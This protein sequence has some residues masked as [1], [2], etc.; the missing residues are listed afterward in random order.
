MQEQ[1]CENCKKKRIVKNIYIEIDDTTEKWCLACRANYKK[2]S[3]IIINQ[4]NL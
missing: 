4:T 3:K 1:I 2:D